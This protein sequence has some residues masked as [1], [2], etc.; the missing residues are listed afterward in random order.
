M[1][2][3]SDGLTQVVYPPHV[4]DTIVVLNI[5]LI[6]SSILAIWMIVDWLSAPKTP[7]KRKK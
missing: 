6:V 1:V 5:A 3:Q 4:L 7:P 2:Q